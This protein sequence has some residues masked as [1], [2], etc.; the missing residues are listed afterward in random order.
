MR[1][2]IF[3]LNNYTPKNFQYKLKNQYKMIMKYKYNFVMR[4]ITIL[5]AICVFGFCFLILC[6][7]E[8]I[9]INFQDSNFKN[10]VLP[11]IIGM[12]VATLAILVVLLPDKPIPWHWMTLIILGGAMLWCTFDLPLYSLGTICA[13]IIG[14][15]EDVK[16]KKN[17]KNLTPIINNIHVNK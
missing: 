3:Y 15:I 5:S 7:I 6:N 12:L 10:K 2:K 14:I 9:F 1:Y 13:G 8:T 4:L 16:K 11:K 17:N